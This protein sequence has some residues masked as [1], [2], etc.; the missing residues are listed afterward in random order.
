MMKLP[1]HKTERRAVVIGGGIAGLLAARV[2]SDYFTSVLLIERDIY[3]AEPVFRPGVPQGRQL[4]ALLARGQ[5][6]LEAFFP[7][8][9]KRILEQG[10]VAGDFLA[11]YAI[12]YPSGW[13]PRIPSSFSVYSCTR[14]LVE[15]QIRQDLLRTT[16]VQIMEEYEVT[17]LQLDGQSRAIAGVQIRKRNRDGQAQ[18]SIVQEIAADLVIDASGR[19]SQ[20]MS[21][22]PALGYEVPRETIVDPLVGY[23]TRLYKPSQDVERTWQTMFM[24]CDLPKILRS[25]FIL[26]VEGG[27][28]QVMMAGR[29][30]DY[31]PT[32]EEG[33]L[34]FARGLIDPALYEA[35]KTAQPLSPAYGFRRTENRWRH[36]EHLRRQP[37]GLLVLGDAACALNPVYGQGI[38]VATMAALTL[39]QCLARAQGNLTGLARR[40]QRQL[41]R[42]NQDA[43]QMATSADYRIL[44][45]E[46][47]PKTWKTKLL[48]RYLEGVS[49]ILPVSPFTSKTFIAVTNLTKSPLAFFHPVIV[50]HVLT[51]KR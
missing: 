1:T 30:K 31:P 6:L 17:T 26:A 9:R 18:E 28:W 35:L 42:T 51:R 20:I 8:F 13:L 50:W 46:E 2:L 12:R 19:A 21:W 34:E 32:D 3:P 44:P 22:L 29:R 38:T 43:W 41:A 48:T 11:D 7:G 15:W 16:D 14:L 24:A 27:C 40:F 23:A 37:E 36:F 49:A 33:F 25:G 47:Q 10:A 45:L 5:Q 4:H 39:S